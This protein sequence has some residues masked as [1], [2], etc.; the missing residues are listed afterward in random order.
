MDMDLRQLPDGWADLLLLQSEGA[1]LFQSSQKAPAEGDIV[2]KVAL[3]FADPVLL[4]IDYQV[5]GHAAEHARFPR[6][7]VKR[8]CGVKMQ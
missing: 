8:R 5:A 4:V 7:R 2:E 6:R 1:F 3:Y